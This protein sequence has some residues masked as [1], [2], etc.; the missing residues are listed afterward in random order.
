[1]LPL[2]YI[3]EG[4]FRKLLKW[5]CEECSEE[6]RPSVPI[7]DD[8][9]IYFKYNILFRKEA[10]YKMHLFTNKKARSIFAVR[11]FYIANE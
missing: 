9:L 1:M 8:Y 11:A 4:C 6:T 10:E 2:F 3:I 7:N 5:K